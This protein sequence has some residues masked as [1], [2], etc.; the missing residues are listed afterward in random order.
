MKVAIIVAVIVI[1]SREAH[2]GEVVARDRH[3]HLPLVLLQPLFCM[4]ILRRQR[5][6]VPVAA[7]APFPRQPAGLPELPAATVACICLLRGRCARSEPARRAAPL[8]P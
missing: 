8:G 6:R 2:F 7:V 1:I 4:R 5:L 3:L